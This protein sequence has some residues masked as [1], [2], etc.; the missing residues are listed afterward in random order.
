MKLAVALA[1]TLAALPSA[2]PQQSSAEYDQLEIRRFRCQSVPYDS[3]DAS[4][5]F[6]MNESGKVVWQL[7]ACNWPAGGTE[8]ACV[9]R[10]RSDKNGALRDIM[11]TCS[12]RKFEKVARQCM[13]AHSLKKE[14][15]SR[16]APVCIGIQY[17]K[18]K[19]RTAVGDTIIDPV[20]VSVRE[21]TTCPEEGY[22][23]PHPE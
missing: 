8:S 10:G 17:K 15:R 5:C 11:A 14:F 7:P 12:N 16:T 22:V 4:G 18:D 21:L 13:S 6:S 23:P 1:V 9:V 2:A 19:N 20:G 3:S